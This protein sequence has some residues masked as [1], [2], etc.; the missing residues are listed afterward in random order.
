MGNRFATHIS[1]A[2]SLKIGDEVEVRL[3]GKIIR[4]NEHG[5]VSIEVASLLHA[6]IYYKGERVPFTEPLSYQ[7]GEEGD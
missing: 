3:P 7:P 6:D 1:P 4:T 2:S 5:L